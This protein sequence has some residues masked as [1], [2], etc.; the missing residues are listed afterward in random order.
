MNSWLTF[1]PYPWQEIIIKHRGEA[2]I[3]PKRD[4][5]GIAQLRIALLV[6]D[7][8]KKREEKRR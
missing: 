6:F 7:A 8:V 3:R 2:I 1:N 4:Y 5:S